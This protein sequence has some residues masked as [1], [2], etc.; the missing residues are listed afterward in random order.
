MNYL[1]HAYLSFQDPELLVGNMLGDF[2]RG[3]RNRAYPSRI[4]DG[5]M[6]HRNIDTFTDAHPVVQQVKKIFHDTV[7]LYDGAFVDISFDHF[8]ANSTLY[9]PAE[10][11]ERFA[12]DCYAVIKAHWDVLPPA[13]HR[14]F[15]YMEEENWLYNYRLES[16]IEKSFK[17]LVRRAKFLDNAVNPYP[18]FEANYDLLQEAFDRFFPKVVAFA[19]ERI[20]LK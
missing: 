1:A 20:A 17:G 4:W 14:L 10:G 11:W 19:K 18:V 16:Q 8:L 6:L 2:V 13:S 7:R 15:L 3:Q 5:I 12:L 9:Q